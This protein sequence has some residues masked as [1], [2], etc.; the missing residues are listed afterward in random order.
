MASAQ[1]GDQAAYA[2]LLVL[3]AGAARAFVRFLGSEAGQKA[4]S[5]CGQASVPVR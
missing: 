3:A 1:Q 4:F 2:E 5:A